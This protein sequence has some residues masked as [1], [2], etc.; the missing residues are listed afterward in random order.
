MEGVCGLAGGG[1]AQAAAASEHCALVER[2]AR[3]QWLGALGVRCL[4]RLAAVVHL[5]ATRT[6]LDSI[7]LGGR[8]PEYHVAAAQGPPARAPV[9][10]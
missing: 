2:G 5:D 9:I 4:L 10:R 7:V 3:G 8:D 1:G 6:Y